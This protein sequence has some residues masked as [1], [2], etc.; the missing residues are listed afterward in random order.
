MFQVFN[1]SLQLQP[2]HRR[3]PKAL[4][5]A[6]GGRQG[7]PGHL[8]LDAAAGGSQPA[9]AQ[10]DVVALQSAGMELPQFPWVPWVASKSCEL[11]K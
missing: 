3:L 5:H 6:A 8:R 11:G 2:G 1:P 4:M 10:H 9:V 7:R